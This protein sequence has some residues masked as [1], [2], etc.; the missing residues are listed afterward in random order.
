MGHTQ[1]AIAQNLRPGHVVKVL[2]LGLFRAETRS[3]TN[4]KKLIYKHMFILL[5]VF[6]Y[7]GY[8]SQYIEE[9]DTGGPHLIPHGGANV[10]YHRQITSMMI[11]LVSLA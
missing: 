1:G 10:C 11:L 4:F 7:V 3:N 8:N 2:L 9:Q 5:Y 6:Y